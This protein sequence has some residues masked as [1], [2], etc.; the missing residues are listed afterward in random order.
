MPVGMNDSRQNRASS[1]IVTVSK[2]L[3]GRM[4]TGNKGPP[5]PA[6][7]ATVQAPARPR[8][9]ARKLHRRRHCPR[10]V[11][12]VIGNTTVPRNSFPQSDPSDSSEYRF[13]T[14][15]EVEDESGD[16]YHD[17]SMSDEELVQSD[18]PGK[19]L[20]FG[21][22]IHKRLMLMTIAQSPNPMRQRQVSDMPV[23][24]RTGANTNKDWH[25]S[26]H[27]PIG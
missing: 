25:D 10:T 19:S 11:L 21:N 27:R 12:T 4:L 8:Q 6:A 2:S 22:P 23:T 9:A 20:L 15:D 3:K 5:Q 24:S 17:V 7:S 1:T 26:Q 18:R 13:E 14:D 16:E